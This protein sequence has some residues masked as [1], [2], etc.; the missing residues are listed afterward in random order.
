MHAGVHVGKVLLEVGG[1]KERLAGSEGVHSAVRGPLVAAAA[2]SAAPADVEF[3]NAPIKVP[4]TAAFMIGCL[5]LARSVACNAPANVR[6]SGVVLKCAEL[7]CGNV[8]PSVAWLLPCAC[9][10]P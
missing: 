5:V 3:V 2:Q 1:S 8:L 4:L 7:D 10:K 9:P 6:F